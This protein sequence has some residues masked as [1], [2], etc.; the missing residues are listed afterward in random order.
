MAENCGS[1]ENF[2]N[3]NLDFKSSLK[4]AA[5]SY[6]EPC[7]RE[8]LVSTTTNLTT[9]ANKGVDEACKQKWKPK[10]SHWSIKIFIF[11]D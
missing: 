7:R 1:V 9:A 11:R 3:L 2:N 4:A 5:H 10:P 8:E 6:P